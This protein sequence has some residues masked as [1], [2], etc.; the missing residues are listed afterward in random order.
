MFLVYFDLASLVFVGLCV[1]L[2]S[3]SFDLLGFAMYISASL[4]ASAV[5]GAR[6]AAASGV[7][8]SG[9]GARGVDGAAS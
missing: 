4:T 6:L 9:P 8:G 3:C 2:D 7:G 5:D 1:Y